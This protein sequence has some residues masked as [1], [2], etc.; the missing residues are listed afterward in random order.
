MRRREFLRSSI[1]VGLG[2]FFRTARVTAQNMPFAFWKSL[3]TGGFFRTTQVMY[4]VSAQGGPNCALQSTQANFLVSAG[5]APT[6]QTTQV[7]LLASGLISGG[8]L[9]TTQVNLLASAG[10]GGVAEMQ[11]TQLN[12]LASA[13]AG[14]AAEMQTTQTYLLVAGKP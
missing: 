7:N 13:G 1:V 8:S 11:T 4:L 14:S 10:S 12:L 9:Q 2:T 3:N 6:F 5:G